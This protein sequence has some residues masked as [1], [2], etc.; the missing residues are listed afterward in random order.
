MSHRLPAY[1]RHPVND[2][3]VSSPQSL[4]PPPPGKPATA[5]QASSQ[6]L[7]LLAVSKI[8]MAMSSKRAAGVSP[9]Q[10]ANA[11]D[12]GGHEELLQAVRVPHGFQHIIEGVHSLHHFERDRQAADLDPLLHPVQQRLQ[13]NTR[14]STQCL[15]Q[16]SGDA[17]PCPTPCIQCTMRVIAGA[18]RTMATAPPLICRRPLQ[19]WLW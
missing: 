13:S 6:A 18:L 15:K 10:A 8:D 11:E 3:P 5:T 2:H 4:Q 1:K 14:Q 7:A 9:P 12:A 17:H 19:I 16:S